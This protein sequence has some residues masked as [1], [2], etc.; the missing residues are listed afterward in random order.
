MNERTIYYIQT[1]ADD[2]ASS[3][4]VESS[5][6]TSGGLDVDIVEGE[7]WKTT[8]VHMDVARRR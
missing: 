8:E 2:F 4:R 5:K 6:E 3:G 1:Y 7:A